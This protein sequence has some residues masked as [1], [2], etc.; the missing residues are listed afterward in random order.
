MSLE[1]FL[2]SNYIEFILPAFIFTF[3]SCL[4][5]YLDTKKEFKKYENLFLKE[6]KKEKLEIAKS[7]K[8]NQAT[9]GSFVY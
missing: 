8:S 9:S 2:P 5:F 7:T 3:I 4:K 1:F 6:D